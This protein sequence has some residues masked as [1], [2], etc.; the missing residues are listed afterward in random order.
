MPRYARGG[1]TDLW[2]VDLEREVVFVYR[3][4]SGDTYQQVQ[5]LR[6]GEHAGP[7]TFPD[8]R[9]PIDSILG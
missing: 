2:L 4:P 9:V 7:V 8:A 6:R 1:V 5:V 3:D